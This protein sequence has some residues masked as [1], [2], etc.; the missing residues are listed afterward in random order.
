MHAIFGRMM[1]ALC[2]SLGGSRDAGGGDF[3]AVHALE[4]YIDMYNA[5]SHKNIAAFIFREMGN[6]SFVV[7]EVSGEQIYMQTLL[8]C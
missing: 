2:A 8:A 6:C 7:S 3:C 4:I 1:L 5:H